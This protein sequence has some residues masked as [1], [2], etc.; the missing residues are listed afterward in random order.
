MFLMQMLVLVVAVTPDLA[1]A[2]S[3]NTSDGSVLYRLESTCGLNDENDTHSLVSMES[4]FLERS[5]E[6]ETMGEKISRL[7]ETLR[8]V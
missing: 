1:S 8:I 7:V 2:K 4:H 6:H 3:R 5:L